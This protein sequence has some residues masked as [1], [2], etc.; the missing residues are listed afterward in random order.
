MFDSETRSIRVF[1]LRR[2]IEAPAEERSG[3]DREAQEGAHSRPIA[4]SSRDLARNGRQ[5]IDSTQSAS[6]VASMGPR[7][8]R[9]FAP[10]ESKPAVK[11]RAAVSIAELTREFET[12]PTGQRDRKAERP[13]GEEAVHRVALV[14]RQR[15]HLPAPARLLA[16][17]T[18]E[19]RH[20]DDARRAP[21]CPEVEQEGL[22]APAGHG[23]RR[24]FERLERERPQRRSPLSRWSSSSSSPPR[25]VERGAQPRGRGGNCREAEDRGAPVQ[26]A[27][28]RERSA[29]RSPRSLRPRASRWSAPRRSS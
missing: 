4:G 22:A 3:A 25:R 11:G 6:S 7:C 5:R 20:L 26:A 14:D 28:S 23:Q 13:I 18:I 1:S 10:E 12:Q 24:P 16:R 27:A 8:W 29:A 21:G 9:T 17:E 19:Q 2:S 15:E